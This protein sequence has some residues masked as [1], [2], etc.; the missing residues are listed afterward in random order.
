MTTTTSTFTR[1]L[2]RGDTAKEFAEIM[3]PDEITRDVIKRALKMNMWRRRRHGSR[4]VGD[5][6]LIV[7]VVQQLSGKWKKEQNTRKNPNI[8]ELIQTAHPTIHHRIIEL[9]LQKTSDTRDEKQVHLSILRSWLTTRIGK[10]ISV[11][12]RGLGI[13]LQ[14][15]ITSFNGKTKCLVQRYDEKHDITDVDQSNYVEF[16]IGAK[17]LPHRGI[18]ERGVVGYRTGF[19]LIPAAPATLKSH[20][21]KKLT[22]KLTENTTLPKDITRLITSFVT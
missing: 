8:I 10:H 20:Y 11:R 15:R 14:R 9:T 22:A 21:K 17:C 13:G 6:G 5:R 19:T 2:Y 12:D 3:I 4:V 1:Q 7:A 18:L 16:Y